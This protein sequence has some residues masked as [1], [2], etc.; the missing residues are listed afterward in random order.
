MKKNV[1]VFEVRPLSPKEAFENEIFTA[2]KEM[3]EGKSYTTEQL[4]AV[5]GL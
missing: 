3:H 2:Q 5:L 1:P 4:R